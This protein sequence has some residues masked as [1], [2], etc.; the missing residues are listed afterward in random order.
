MIT[1]ENYYLEYKKVS[2]LIDE[3]YIYVAAIFLAIIAII[4]L[5]I[6][7]YFVHNSIALFILSLAYLPILNYI[8]K[9]LDKPISSQIRKIKINKLKKLTNNKKI[10]PDNFEIEHYDFILK[11]LKNTLST[12]KINEDIYKSF[13]KSHL[14]DYLASNKNILGDN[15]YVPFIFGS[16]YV[17]TLQAFYSLTT[18]IDEVMK[19][20]AIVIIVSALIAWIIYFIKQSSHSKYDDISKLIFYTEMIFQEQEGK[21]KH[22]QLL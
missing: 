20:L 16:I 13:Y 12:H 9:L 2:L 15:I 19:T 7:I 11:N 4:P 21:I 22:S 5:P 18:T 3:K 17:G 14:K 6:L 1:P 10:Y 8:L